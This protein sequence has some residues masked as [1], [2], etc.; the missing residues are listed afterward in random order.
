MFHAAGGAAR[1]GGVAA[2][3]P[4]ACRTTH[5]QPQLHSGLPWK[6]IRAL[7]R[8]IAPASPAPIEGE[9]IGLPMLQVKYN[10]R[11][12]MLGKLRQ[13]NLIR[14]TPVRKASNLNRFTYIMGFTSFTE[15]PFD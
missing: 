9:P 8:L 15:P 10:G 11:T 12:V 13:H 2:L 14:Y 1:K 5:T 7:S 3:G 6:G 4:S